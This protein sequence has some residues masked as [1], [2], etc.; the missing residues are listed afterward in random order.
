MSTSLLSIAK[1]GLDAASLGLATTNHNISNVNTAGYSRQQII[2]AAATA[3]SNGSGYVGS[4]VQVTSIK[5]VAEDYLTQQVQVATADDAASTAAV[6]YLNQISD[7]LTSDSSSLSSSLDSF[8]SSLQTLSAT[9]SD[10]TAR[11]SAISAAQS[12]VNRFNTLDGQL[13][14]MSSEIG[15]RLQSSATQINSYAQQIS[16]LNDQIALQQ[17]SGNTPNDLLDQRDQLITDLSSLTRVS[18]VA[19]SDG[20]VNVFLASGDA[21]V[22]GNQANKLVVQA[23]A[24]DPERFSM[25]VQGE[26]TGGVART[27][28]SSVDLG[29]TIGGLMTAQTSIADTRNQLGRI[30]VAFADAINQQQANGVDLNGTQGADLFS[31]GSPKSFA[32]SG[33]TGAISVSYADTTALTGSDYK[34]DFDGTQYTLT[35]RSDGTATTYTSL[36]QTVDGLT[37]SAT[38][39]P[40]AGDSFII[41]PTREAASGISMA[42]TNGDKIAAGTTNASG[43]N[44]NINAMAAL[45][46][47]NLVNGKTLGDANGTLMGQIGNAASAMQTE[48][49]TNSTLLQQATTQQQSVSGVNLDEEAANLLKY[50]QAYQAAAKA[51]S[52]AN[53]VFQSIL[54]IMG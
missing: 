52:I 39:A 8:F 54:D 35:R 14:S 53:E 3:N 5:R 7:N 51:M 44:T 28:Q 49:S 37:I 50:Q 32:L 42:T 48:A 26:S 30:A 1:S 10:A 22:L 41:Q 47:A 36:P 25:A 27:I 12:L 33:S 40:A 11:Q 13:T 17:N 24:S 23:D 34:L 19:Q 6:G 45:V 38:T 21:L 18:T 2:Q 29:G 31:I 4:G 16:K 20:R 43:D 15:Q 46:S 9:P